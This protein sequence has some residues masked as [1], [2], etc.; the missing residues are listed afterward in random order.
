M[1]NIATKISLLILIGVIISACNATKRVPKGKLL[2][3]KNEILV[4]DKKEK[5][6][7]V[8]SQLYQKPNTSILGYRLRLNLY[9][10]ALKN[11]D[12][13]YKAKFIKN[14]GKYKR[15]AKW[16]SKKQVDRLGKSFWYYG[17]HNF[18]KKTGEPP[19]I[20]D[21]KSTAKSTLRLK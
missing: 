4:N 1:R 8:T 14:P 6:D 11:P 20:I 10:L 15:Q 17:I 13:T 18:L 12:S 5:S 16:L 9:N 21:K 7:N 2:L 3:T 19:V